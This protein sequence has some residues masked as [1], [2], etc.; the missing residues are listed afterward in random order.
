MG[1]FVF[2]NPEF[3]FKL[4]RM[5]F[6]TKLNKQYLFGAAFVQRHT[7]KL[8]HK[9][10]FYKLCC[11]IKGTC[12]WNHLNYIMV[13]ISATSLW[14][15]NVLYSG[16]WQSVSETW[17]THLPYKIIVCLCFWELYLSFVCARSGL[18]LHKHNYVQMTHAYSLNAH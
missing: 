3:I 15:Y 7:V 12:P 6:H 14:T 8:V 9:S 1:I 16:S 5:Y 17:L 2:L 18:P 10:T 11:N 13:R 4:R